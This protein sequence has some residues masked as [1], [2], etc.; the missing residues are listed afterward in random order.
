ELK[1]KYSIEH[2]AIPYPTLNLGHIHGGD[3]AN[4]ICGCCELHIDIRPLPGLSIQELQLL[5]LNAIKP[6]NDEFP[7]SV[8]VVDMHEPIPAFSGAND[9]ALVKL[10]EKISEEQAVA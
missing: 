8:S 4:R 3:N 9:N 1:N 10:A 6:I 2:F 7:N 5:L